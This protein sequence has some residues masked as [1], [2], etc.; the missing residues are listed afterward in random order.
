MKQLGAGV[1]GSLMRGESP[2]G[3]DLCWDTPTGELCCPECLDEDSGTIDYPCPTVAE[4]AEAL[5]VEP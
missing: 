1:S 2:Q 5:G 4:I 3:D